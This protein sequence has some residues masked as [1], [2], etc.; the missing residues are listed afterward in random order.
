[1]LS[2][3]KIVGHGGLTMKNIWICIA[4]VI[5]GCS[6]A[7]LPLS[8]ADPAVLQVSAVDSTGQVIE[9]A[10]VFLNG[11][12]VGVT[13]YE[14][15][16]LQPGLLTLRLLKENY[17]IYTHQ[18]VVEQ[19]K[20]Y[21]VEAVLKALPPTDG[22]LLVTVNVD[23][24]RIVV[25]DASGNEVAESRERTTTFV[26]PAGAYV[27]TGEKKGCPAQQQAVQIE[28]GKSAV[29]NIRI[30][31]PTYQPPALSFTID[32]D[33][34]QVNTPFQLTWNSNGSQVIIDQGVGTRGPS[35]S[36]TITSATPG[37]KVYTATAF[38]DN[39]LTTQAKDSVYIAPEV[40]QAPELEFTVQQDSVMYG[41]YVRIEWSS[42]GYQ[43]VIDQSVGP[44]G[45][46]GS[47]EILFD[48]PG[49][50]VFTATA[51]GEHNTLSIKQ[52]S[53]FVKEAPAPANPVVFLT[54]TRLVTVNT[55]AT[56]TWHTQNAD[57]LVIDYVD[58]P[59]A[60]GSYDVTFTTPGIRIVTATA[61][62][63][64]GYVAVSDTIEV[65]E[66]AVDPVDDIIIVENRHVRADQGES[67]MS[68]LNGTSFE[69][70]TAGRYKLLTEVWYNSGDEQL[71]ESFYIEIAPPAGG[72]VLPQDP[73]AGFHKVIADDPGTPHTATR[74][75]GL[76]ELSTGSHRIDVYHY[77]KIATFYPQF[78]NGEI[79]GP[80]SVKILGF[81][82][83]FVGN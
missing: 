36:E 42:N 34:V 69:I 48:N 44:R 9:G 4:F 21:N 18:F 76:F 6:K 62:N 53:V 2:K 3:K 14:T 5:F 23:S 78:L 75:S 40:F 20:D 31:T 55:P 17:H 11:T 45:P 19:G 59:E 28:A 49:M 10:D 38:G 50:K 15:E 43:V 64:A 16:N 35:G 61:F 77:A 25:K 39:N 58:N 37:L 63:Q 32:A 60:Q 30:E 24:A 81:K 72:V 47:E 71:N 83:V 80:E 70:T 66:P 56:I 46:V 67:G 82:L 26:L 33:T 41:E 79:N 8:S 74:E 22:E 54:A 1:M 73:N 52:D 27:V 29:V 68:D 65:V 51:Y 57:F 7:E 12:K 13:P